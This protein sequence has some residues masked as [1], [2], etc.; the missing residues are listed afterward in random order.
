MNFK[1][2][3]NTRSPRLVWLLALGLTLLV[4][5]VVLANS[6][7]DK[8]AVM[9]MSSMPTPP[10]AP[11]PQ[12]LAVT[13]FSQLS[14]ISYVGRWAAYESRA[15]DVAC[16]NTNHNAGCA[17]MSTDTLYDIILYDRGSIIDP[18]TGQASADVSWD[19]QAWAITDKGEISGTK[20]HSTYPVL[21][22]FDK[23]AW[24][25]EDSNTCKDARYV[26]FQT[27]SDNLVPGDTNGKQ[28]IYLYDRVDYTSPFTLVSKPDPSTGYDLANHHSGGPLISALYNEGVPVV[29]NL[30]V[31]LYNPAHPGADI[32]LR[33]VDEGGSTS[34]YPEVV[35]ESKAS[36]LVSS[37]NFY[38]YGKQQIYVRDIENGT[39]SLLSRN[40]N[41]TPPP[42]LPY[43]GANGDCT[44]PVAAPPYPLTDLADNVLMAAGRYVAFVSKASNLGVTSNGKAQIYLLDR[45][46]DNDKVLDETDD[47]GKPKTYLVSKNITLNAPGDGESWHPG[48]AVDPD[49]L[50]VR[51]VFNSTSTNLVSSDANGALSDVFLYQF[52][53][54]TPNTPQMYLLSRSGG[55]SGTQGNLDSLAPSISPSGKI[56]SF[57]SYA[58]NLI[59]DD[60]NYYCHLSLGSQIYTNCPDVFVRDISD[61]DD[62]LNGE[63][64]RASLSVTGE[65]GEPSLPSGQSN[66]NSGLSRLSGDGQFVSF[67]SQADFRGIGGGQATYQQVYMADQGIPPGNPLVRP[68]SA[69]LYTP[70]NQSADVTFTVKFL[71]T[72]MDLTGQPSISLTGADAAY[73][74][75]LND[76]CSGGN[77]LQPG[78][79]DTCTFD[80]RFTPATNDRSVRKAQV[81][82]P[83]GYRDAAHQ[84]LDPRGRIYI[85]VRGHVVI[86]F[87]P[88]ISP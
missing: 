49:T 78:N 76:T 14:S 60:T 37:T 9:V 65:Q 25:C 50:K 53:Y 45:D 18:T 87:L 23:D 33:R 41:F 52:D 61:P 19:D 3:W 84:Q 8:F 39:T 54:S 20:G 73:F 31:T 55:S 1:P 83:L 35:F 77:F 59:M 16:G 44:H 71:G 81:V 64:W 79:P 7:S 15:Y 58:T 62:P 13:G 24:N 69:N 26:V 85:S 12:S 47:T 57:T 51:V 38:L 22:R 10:P 66:L 63:I 70:L 11:T 67:A 42:G 43:Q 28:D 6:T 48:V 46:P 2:F 75:I 21:S 82:F 17:A 80:V 29:N 34:Y 32:Y 72:G 40:W 4:S 56:V 5:G 88:L 74:Q 68:S 27:F 36:N 30:P 86:T